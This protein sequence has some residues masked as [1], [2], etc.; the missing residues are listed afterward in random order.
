MGG[1]SLGNL[2]ESAHVSKPECL[3]YLKAGMQMT[4]LKYLMEYRLQKAA[5]LLATTDEPIG[6]IAMNV[7]FKQSSL[8]GK[9]FKEITGCSLRDYRY[10]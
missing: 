3:R 6:T 1:I 9:C 7:G 4:S 2:V 8:F 5:E 10:K